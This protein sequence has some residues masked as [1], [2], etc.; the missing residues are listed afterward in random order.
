[1]SAQARKTAVFK[2]RYTEKEYNG[3]GRKEDGIRGRRREEGRGKREYG[4]GWN[5]VG[6]GSGTKTARKRC[7]QG[8]EEV[9]E[10]EQVHQ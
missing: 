6:A 8:Q 3:G 4:S 1:M 10:E 7:G 9:V 2:E 5:Q